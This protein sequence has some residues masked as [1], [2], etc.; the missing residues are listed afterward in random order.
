[1]TRREAEVLAGVAAGQTNAE[2]PAMLPIAPGTVKKHLDHI[3][4]KLGVGS[5]TEAAMKAIARPSPPA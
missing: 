3:Y 4:E 1:L 5:R 2:I